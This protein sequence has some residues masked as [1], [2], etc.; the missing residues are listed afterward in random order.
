MKNGFTMRLVGALALCAALATGSAFAATDQFLKSQGLRQEAADAAAK[1]DF[2]AARVALTEA[3]RLR[4]GHP[5]I[6]LALASAE[7]HTGDEESAM[8]HLQQYATMG[9]VARIADRPEFLPLALKPRFIGAKVQIEM[10]GEP[11]GAPVKAFALGDGAALFEGIA[12]DGAQAFAG[13]VR[14]RRIVRIVGGIAEDFVAP[15][16]DGLFSVFGLAV[17]KPRGLLWAA[18]TAG[19]L[20]PGL[21]PGEIGSAGVF[22]FDLETGALRA[23]AVLGPDIKAMLGD[24]A[25]AAD[26]TVYATDSANAAIWRL[27]PGA[28]ALERVFDDRRFVSP[29]GIAVTPDQRRILVADYA[30]GL[31]A[32]DLETAKM[33]SVSAPSAVT[34]LGIDGI[35]FADSGTLIAS[36]NGIA[37]ERIVA[38]ALDPDPASETVDIRRMRVIAANSPLHD[39]ITLAAAAGPFVYYIANAPWARFD[40][41]GKDTGKGPFPEAIVAK[42]AIGP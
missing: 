42:V 3:L 27:K 30:M 32:I 22:A 11:K 15:G 9:L 37:P 4:P 41:E 34:L 7:A 13:S 38:L 1:G 21:A 12:V 17:D 40:P 24:V 14:E 25:V 36:Q 2:A 26:G 33:T 16:A 8:T 10:N 31:Y 20:T 39:G 23:K 18:S 19:V 35:S 5:G 6:L 29:Q 28:D